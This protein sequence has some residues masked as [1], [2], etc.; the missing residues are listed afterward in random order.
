M[1][2]TARLYL[3]SDLVADILLRYPGVRVELV[4]QNSMD[5][6]EDLRR[7]RLEAAIIALPIADDGLK[8]VPVMRD[9]IVYVSTD[10][11]RLRRPITPTDLAGASLVLSE[12]SWGNEDSTR[13]Q[14]LRAVQSVGGTLRTRIEVEDIETALEIAAA[15]LADT[16]TARGLLHSLGDRLSPRMG[17]VPL[18][19]KL[20]D[21]FAIVH[22]REAQL[23]PAT[24]AVVA[25]AVARMKQVGAA[26]KG[27]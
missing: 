20:F 17:W 23:S 27:T 8:V 22:R 11:E 4:G 24:K 16:I 1:F 18:R 3:G 6:L 21:E 14:L 9:E 7:G 2:G 10:P 26:V 25:L 19:P 15:G 12:V 5:V 13:R